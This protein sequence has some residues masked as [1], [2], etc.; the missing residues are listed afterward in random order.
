MMRHIPSLIKQT[1]QA[2]GEI[3]P[4]QHAGALAF[5]ALLS[6]T[7]LLVVATGVAETALSNVI[8]TENE[9]ERVVEQVESITGPQ[10]ANALR[11]YITDN[12]TSFG[13]GF[14]PTVISV[15]T[16]T[17]GAT[18][19]FAQLQRSLNA[20]WRAETDQGLVNTLQ[21]RLIGFLLV[22]LIG[23]LLLV[24]VLMDVAIVGATRLVRDLIPLPP[25]A[26]RA[27][28]IGEG[29][30]SF[31]LIGALFGLI[32]RVLP[33]EKTAWRDALIGGLV[34]AA[35]FGIGQ[36]GIGVY[37]RLANPA[38]SSVV[39]SALILL[40][41]VYYSSLVFLFGAQ[42]THTFTTFQ[43]EETGDEASYSR[44]TES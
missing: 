37:L 19:F 27:V 29:I 20:V 10:I 24:L 8:T 2:F 35:L 41:W 16:L 43:P 6:I 26:I 17:I 39:G 1:V 9:A 31:G 11:P 7:P 21:A 23:V 44:A 36:A 4:P 25:V 34:T 28:R 12:Q 38:A 14:V 32:F 3:L 30:L 33:D 13:G 5:F 15:V 40:L 22:L 42:F 18:A